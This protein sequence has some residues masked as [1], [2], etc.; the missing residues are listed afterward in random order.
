MFQL[1]NKV[2]T[3]TVYSRITL[4]SFLLFNRVLIRIND[5]IIKNLKYRIQ[6]SLIPLNQRKT[7]TKILL[8]LLETRNKTVSIV[9]KNKILLKRLRLKKVNIRMTH[10]PTM[11]FSN[12]RK[13]IRI[14][15]RTEQNTTVSMTLSTILI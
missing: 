4:L 7:L 3:G 1:L 11:D 6:L 15:Y 13:R 9:A 12:S 2:W 5:K 14:K 10:L 8:G